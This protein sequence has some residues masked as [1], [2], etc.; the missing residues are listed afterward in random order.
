MYTLFGLF[1]FLLAVATAEKY[2]MVLSTDNDW[3]T[4]YISSESCRVYDTLVKGAS[5]PENHS[6]L[7]RPDVVRKQENPF[8]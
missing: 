7:T 6:F 4:Y 1:G 5:T 3:E 2:A 8:Q